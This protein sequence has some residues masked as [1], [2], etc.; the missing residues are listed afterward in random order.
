MNDRIPGSCYSNPIRYR[1]YLIYLSDMSAISGDDWAW[2]H[3]AYDGAPD[4]PLRHLCGTARSEVECRR[5]IDE[6]LDT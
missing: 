5:V 2:C 6:M 4:S 3:E 1:G